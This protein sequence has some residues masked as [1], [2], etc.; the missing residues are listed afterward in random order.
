ML[1]KNISAGRVSTVF[2]S[3]QSSLDV[4][5]GKPPF[6]ARRTMGGK[7]CDAYEF[8]RDKAEK[9]RAAQRAGKRQRKRKRN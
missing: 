3:P 2:F 7:V 8:D 6:W 4:L 1:Q 9:L 5:E